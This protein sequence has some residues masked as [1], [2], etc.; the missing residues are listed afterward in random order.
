MAHIISGFIADSHL[1]QE[2]SRDLPGGVAIPLAHGIG[3]LPITAELVMQL[4]DRPH[5]DEVIKGFFGLLTPAIVALAERT[6]RSGRLG[7]IETEFSGGPGWQL[8]MMWEHGRISF[9][10]V[11]KEVR[12]VTALDPI[13]SFLEAMGVRA[14][15]EADQFEVVGLHRYRSNEAW[16]TSVDVRRQGIGPV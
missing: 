14:D 5:D 3:F 15:G 16:L 2:L 7:W 10:P 8:A 4:G 1:I 9:G 6:S 13:N 11:I 12:S